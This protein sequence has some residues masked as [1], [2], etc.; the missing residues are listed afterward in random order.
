MNIRDLKY[1]VAIA[2]YQHF[3]QAAV[4]CHVSQPAL[5]MQIKKLETVLGV[6]LIERTTKSARLTDAGKLMTNHAR[7]ILYKVDTMKEAAKMANDPFSGE[8]RLGV[9][10]TLAPY[11]LPH[12]I[13]GLN[14]QFP[15]LTL[16]LI[17]DQTAHLMYKLNQGQIDAALLAFP[18]TEKDLV[19]LPLFEED[20]LLAIPD[21]HSLSKRKHARFADIE[22]QS[23][24]LLEDGH[25]LRD[26]ALKVCHKANAS[27]TK[28]FQATSLE[29]LRHMVASN[30]GITLIPALAER[31]GD[32]IHYLS[33]MNPKPSRMIGMSW[34]S[35]SARTVVLEHMTKVIRNLMSKEKRVKI[36]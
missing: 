4:A 3:G 2:D 10:P 25:C 26:Q 9:I 15:K 24:L 14:K 6:Q 23:L 21:Q 29:T 35:T 34:R 36:V 28:G 20:F 27:E 13:K 31:K 1:L 5:S 7:E 19:A 30:V 33:F 18:L 12:I 8:I 22:N 11:L 17:E 32:G 16:F